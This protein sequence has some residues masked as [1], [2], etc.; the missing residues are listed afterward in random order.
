[1]LV[2]QNFTFVGVVYNNY[3]DTFD[4]CRSLAEMVLGE[5]R[6]IC[7]LVDNSD[8][9]DI[10]EEVDSLAVEFSFVK[11]LRPS[12]NLGYFGA[13][14]Y[15]FDSE[16][17]N[18]KDIVLLCNNDLVFDS[19]FCKNFLCARYP[20][21]VFVVCPD[22]ITVDGVYQNP[23]VLTPWGRIARL[24]LD[25]YFT[26]FY[27]ACLLKGGQRC[28]HRL[29]FGKKRV[30]SSAPGYL[31]LGIGA[32]YVL[33]PDFLN[34]F[35]RL[36]FPHFLYGEEAYLT[37]QVHSVGGKLY[38]DPSLKV[39]HKES[40]TLSKLPSRTTYEFGREGYWHYRDFY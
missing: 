21:D 31:H 18:S 25:L 9:R 3:Q 2:S 33:L 30:E 6:L 37:K 34:K 29:G 1:M 14:N 28:L 17:F 11:I 36:D 12:Q 27:M 22:V 32:C 7:I 10:Q 24:K 40:A 38:Y 4:F 35:S 8:R 26:H 13:F 15:F 19:E 5:S 20:E 16:L 23:H 39:L